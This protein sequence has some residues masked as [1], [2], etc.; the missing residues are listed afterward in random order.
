MVEVAEVILVQMKLGNK[1]SDIKQNK[2]LMYILAPE[3]TVITLNIGTDMP[4]QTV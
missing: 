1:L 4:E 3:Y 2:Y